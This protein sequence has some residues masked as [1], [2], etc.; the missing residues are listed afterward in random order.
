MA[1]AHTNGRKLYDDSCLRSIYFFIKIS[2]WLEARRH[3]NENG[4]NLKKYV[5]MEKVLLKIMLRIC[6]QIR[7][8]E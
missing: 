7:F 2:G 1:P 3:N 5:H 4:E 6:G 8:H